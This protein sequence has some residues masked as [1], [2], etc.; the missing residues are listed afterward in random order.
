MAHLGTSHPEAGAY[1]LA[2][3]GLPEPIIEC[4]AFHHHPSLLEGEV[5]ARAILH[6]ATAMID[7]QLGEQREE[8][9]DRTLIARAG[10]TDV[11]AT[12]RALVSR[13]LTAG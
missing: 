3:W 6:A 2:A 12:W 5:R 4:V 11:I 10:Y 9:L 8:A 7:H 13:E 1:L